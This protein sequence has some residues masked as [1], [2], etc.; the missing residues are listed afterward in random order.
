VTASSDRGSDTSSLSS[1]LLREPS[2]LL[3]AV[4]VIIRIIIA[5]VAITK[6]AGGPVVD[7]DVLRFHALA[8]MEGTPWRDF[9]VE[10]APLEASIILLIGRGT[11]ASTGR[12]VVVLAFVADLA[13]AAALGA[14]WGRGAATRYLLIGLPLLSFIYFRLDAIPIALTMSGLVLARRGRAG[15]ASPLLAAGVLTKVWP[16]VVLPALLLEGRRRALAWTA[17]I[18]AAGLAGWVA[19]A[20]TSGPTQVATFRGAVGWSVESVVGTLVWIATGA[21]PMLEGGAPRVGAIPDPVRLILSVGLGLTLIAVWLRARRY[22]GDPVGGPALAAVAALL[23]WS[24]I[25]S[26][27]YALWLTPFLAIA[28]GD[29]VGRIGARLGAAAVLGTGV[30]RVVAASTSVVAIEQL[31]LLLRNGAVVGIVVWWFVATRERAVRS[32]E[33]VEG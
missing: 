9:E 33:V 11:V 18:V 27:Q 29:P 30:V 8:H 17:A 5:S 28:A 13:T 7:D 21:A 16:T 25:F 6:L 32:L 19:I 31:L 23:V 12:A 15:R 14:G 2:L 4:L 24:P 1:G 22:T 10:Y 26:L 3:I 20:G